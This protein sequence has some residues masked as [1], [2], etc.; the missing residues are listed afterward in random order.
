MGQWKALPETIWRKAVDYW[1]TLWVRVL[2]MG[3]L[4]LLAIGLTQLISP[5]IPDELSA[6]VGGQAADRLLDIIAN[7]MLA[8]TIFALTVMVSVHRNTASQW[9]P[10]VHRLILRDPTT[11]NT[12]ATF[13]GAYVYALA[14]IILREIGI[15]SDDR[16]LVLFVMTVFVLILIVYA[17]VRWT[18]HL[19]TF[20]SLIDTT[21]Q[22][23]EI[24]VRQFRERLET[25]CLGANPLREVPEGAVP[26][27][28]KKA[29]YVSMMYQESL[30]AQ[31]RERE[32]EIYLVAPPGKFLHMNETMAYVTG[33]DEVE[34]DPDE[35]RSI[36]DMLRDHVVVEDLRTYEQD[37]RFGLIVMGEIGS[38]A[39]SPGINDPGTAID[40]I[41]RIARILSDF[42]GEGDRIGD[43]VHERLYVPVMEPEDLLEDGFGS[44]ARDG[45][46]VI[47]VQQRLQKILKGLMSHPDPGLSAAAK[48]TAIIEF[49]R[50]M[51]GLKFDN[52][53]LR[54]ANSADDSVVEAAEEQDQSA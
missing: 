2:L 28:T 38:K 4:A 24:T 42:E 44:I 41:G 46:G 39:L 47:E 32:I 49:R 43:V 1:R 22:V 40:V 10:R 36:G 48:Q 33:T 25:P 14:G 50:A 37:P 11:Q 13:I 51:Q 20:G 23:E 7:A 16:A 12:L 26:V 9:T 53:R 15:Y 19:Q 31:A 27:R 54:L 18:L 29:G 21:R 52:D 45:A 30:N 35:G 34:S 6:F 8:A 17:L 3:A 5:L